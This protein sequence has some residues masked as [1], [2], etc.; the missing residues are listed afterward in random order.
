V[1]GKN[2]GIKVHFLGLFD[3][4]NSISIFD[5]THRKNSLPPEVYGTANHIRHAVSVDERR[6]KFKVALL[7]QDRVLMG[8][9]TEDVKEVGNLTFH[10]FFY[11]IFIFIFIFIGKQDYPIGIEIYKYGSLQFF[12]VL[13][14]LANL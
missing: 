4:V 8:A 7:S 12:K 10:D 9:E 6:V 13:Y 5:F 3:T 14:N 11:F 1:P 2:S